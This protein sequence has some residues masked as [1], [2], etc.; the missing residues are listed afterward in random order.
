MA[1]WIAGV[2][3]FRIN[4]ENIEY[5]LVHSLESGRLTPPEGYVNEGESPLMRVTAINKVR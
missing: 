2:I 1:Q 5:L 3:V 4:D